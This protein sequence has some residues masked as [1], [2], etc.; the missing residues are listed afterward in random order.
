MIDVDVSYAVLVGMV[1]T[2]NPCGFAM[3][4]AYLSYFLGLDATDRSSSTIARVAR[5]LVV[6]LSL[7]AGFLSVFLVLGTTIHLGVD[8]LYDLAQWATLVIGV[9]LVGLGVAM[10][11]GYRLPFLVPKLERG[12]TSQ[13]VGSMLLFG[14]SYAVASLGCSLPT[15]LIVLFGSAKRSGWLSGAVSFLC[16]GLGFALVL[17]ALTVSLALAHGG[18]LRALRRAMRVVDQA[19]AVLLVLAGAY[20]AWY[21]W[22]EVRGSGS[23]LTDRGFDVSARLTELLDSIGVGTLSAVLGAVVAAAVGV[24]A[25]R[26]RQPGA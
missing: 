18:F 21:G 17:T 23:D 15:F 13:S 26:R 11:F 8:A 25:W 9:A 1:V 2:V 10:L 19:A 16:Y 20:V 24:V 5:A 3:L 6:S 7:S 4:P 22:T 14:V 12:G